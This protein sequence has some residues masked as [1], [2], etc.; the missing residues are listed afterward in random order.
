MPS[1]P[2]DGEKTL[3]NTGSSAGPRTGADTI[4]GAGAHT[5]TGA[6]TFVC[7]LLFYIYGHIKI[8]TNW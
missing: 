8:G 2:I 1:E 7:L 6:N 5:G 4:A 3:S